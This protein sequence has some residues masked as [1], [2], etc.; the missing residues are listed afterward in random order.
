MDELTERLESQQ[1]AADRDRDDLRLQH[2]Q[3]QQ[4]LRARIEDLTGEKATLGET[5]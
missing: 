5:H 2:E 3:L 1:Q 4:Q